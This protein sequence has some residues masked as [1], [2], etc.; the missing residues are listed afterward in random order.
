MEFGVTSEN[1]VGTADLGVLVFSTVWAE[2][3]DKYVNFP[4]LEI[5]NWKLCFE[6]V[7]WKEMK[8]CDSI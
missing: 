8:E 1:S 5:V 4:I 7:K 2:G 3:G 6:F